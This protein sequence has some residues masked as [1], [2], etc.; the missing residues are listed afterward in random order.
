MDNIF[1][2]I[3][4][5]PAAIPILVLLIVCAV[6][7]IFIKLERKMSILYPL[8]SIDDICAPHNVALSFFTTRLYIRGTFSAT[9]I[10]RLQSL[11]TIVRAV[12]IKQVIVEPLVSSDRRNDLIRAMVTLSNHCKVYVTDE[13][14]VLEPFVSLAKRLYETESD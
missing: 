12:G 6:L 7:Y 10:T 13:Q 14:Y 5:W 11:T 1:F 9:S 4:H 2:L 8:R 3:D